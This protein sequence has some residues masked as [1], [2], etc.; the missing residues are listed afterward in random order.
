MTFEDGSNARKKCAIFEIGWN[1]RR[2]L[3]SVVASSPRSERSARLRLCR[4]SRQAGHLDQPLTVGTLYVVGAPVGGPSD[5]TRR[6]LRILRQVAVIVG[7]DDGSIRQLLAQLELTAASVASSVESVL[8]ALE[9]DDVA[10]LSSGWLLGLSGPGELLVRAAIEH[11]FPV[12]PI[13]GPV[14]PLT[15]LVLSGLPAHSFVWLGELSW[16]SP[17]PRTPLA[18]LAHDPRTVI[19]VVPALHLPEVGAELYLALGLRP[20][21]VVGPS[22]RGAK[23]IWR[24]TLGEL[25]GSP[26]METITGRCVLVIG[27]EEERTARWEEDRLRARVEALRARGLGAREIGQQLAGE[28]GWP[29]REIYR[30]V[31]EIGQPDG[32]SREE[33]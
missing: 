33:S 31:V 21:V 3:P 25:S 7:D 20:L 10:F 17:D 12:V 5:L 15:A 19:A 9:K 16:P 13:P 22:D 29:R 23:V 18:D 11:H 27:G 6:A 30:M 24:G 1:G 8:E 28:S 2:I 4:R 14:L 26:V 32:H